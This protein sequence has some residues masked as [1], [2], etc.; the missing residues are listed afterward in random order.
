M[1]SSL[2]NLDELFIQDVLQS[3]KLYLIPE[4]EQILHELEE[5][6]NPIIEPDTSEH[7][8]LK[9]KSLLAEQMTARVN[10]TIKIIDQQCHRLYTWIPECTEK[11]LESGGVGLSAEAFKIHSHITRNLNQAIFFL[12]KLAKELETEVQTQDYKWE[13]SL[14]YLRQGIGY[15]QKYINEELRPDALNVA[16]TRSPVPVQQIRRIQRY[17][18]L[19]SAHSLELSLRLKTEL[20]K[21]IQSSTDSIELSSDF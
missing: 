8:A 17:I 7:D 19:L 11:I 3:G 1:I 2:S 9:Q 14:F 20:S 18:N 16:I 15:C 5:A 12:L 6:Q 4:L 21:S 10:F 13:F